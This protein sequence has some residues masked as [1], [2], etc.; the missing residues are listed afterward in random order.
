[1]STMNS[2]KRLVTA[3]HLA[4]ALGLGMLAAAVALPAISHAQDGPTPLIGD[5]GLPVPR[6][7]PGERTRAIL[8]LQN[9]TSNGRRPTISAAESQKM[10]NNYID[11]IGKGGAGAPIKGIGEGAEFATSGN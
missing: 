9:G 5:D 4:L 1:M 6:L 10:Y 11:S 7:A 8:Q 2:T 3:G